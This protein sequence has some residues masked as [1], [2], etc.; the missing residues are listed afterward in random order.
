[1][2]KIWDDKD[3]A[4]G[5]RPSSLSVR[6]QSNGENILGVSLNA[7]NGWSATVSNLPL[8]ENG[9]PIEY[10]WAE[11][12][13]SGYYPVSSV[14][15]G[16]TTTFTNSNL[17]TLTIHYQYSNGETAFDDYVATNAVGEKY[18]VESP[19]LAGY[20][21]S[22]TEVDG[23]QPAENVEFFVIYTPEDGVEPTPEPQV[24]PTPVPTET[25]KPSDEPEPIKDV[26][27]PR[28]IEP[29][30]EHP[31]VVPEPNILVDIDDLGTALGLG[32][33][34]INNGGY[35]LE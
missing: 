13:I 9:S 23:V 32:D 24:T 31:V 25:P 18:S 15:S 7:E 27:E 11:Q 8:N 10:T 6:L 21:V 16:N 3:N 29:D 22:L 33:V 34:F 14:R 28:I 26:P 4:G 30:E 1:V 17:Y 12:S 20:T 35:A 5:T 19:E 2:N